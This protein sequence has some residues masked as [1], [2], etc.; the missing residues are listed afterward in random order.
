MKINPLLNSWNSTLNS[1]KSYRH[2]A[3]KMIIEAVDNG[4]SVKDISLHVFQNSLYEVEDCGR[5]IR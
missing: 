4:I 3:G 1:L 2:S 5:R